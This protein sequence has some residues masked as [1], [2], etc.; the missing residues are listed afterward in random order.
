MKIDEVRGHLS[1]ISLYLL[2][3]PFIFFYLLLSSYIFVF[4]TSPKGEDGRGL[5]FFLLSSK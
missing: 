5:Y 2:L 3:S 1:F 4:N